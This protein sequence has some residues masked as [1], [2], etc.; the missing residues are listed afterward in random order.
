MIKLLSLLVLVFIL[1][2][3]SAK[4]E[5]EQIVKTIEVNVDVPNEYLE[6]EELP[7]IPLLDN[8]SKDSTVM[9]Y[10]VDLWNSADSCKKDLESIKQYLK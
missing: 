9:N 7:K 2:G 4:V 10:I 5:P 3:C 8:K 1:V 6:C